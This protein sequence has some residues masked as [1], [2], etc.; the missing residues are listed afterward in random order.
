MASIS[1]FI[2]DYGRMPAGYFRRT[3]RPY[4]SF[5]CAVD[6]IS[7]EFRLIMA[8]LFAIFF[9][10]DVFRIRADFI[11]KRAGNALLFPARNMMLYVQ[12]H[13]KR[14]TSIGSRAI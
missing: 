10:V 12:T 14:R 9:D 1:V 4:S 8:S 7:P 2:A 5:R 11:P 3:W 13:E 6:A